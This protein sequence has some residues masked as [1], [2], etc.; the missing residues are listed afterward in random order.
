[1]KLQL[2]RKSFENYVRLGFEYGSGKSIDKKS[3]LDLKKIS[4][5][6][7]AVL[8]VDDI[9]DNSKTRNGKSC[10]YLQK[11]LQ[12]AIVQAELSKV[13]AIQSLTKVMQINKT[14]DSFQK[15]VLEK[16]FDF[17]KNIYLGEQL[18]LELCKSKSDITTIL[19][20]YNLM[21]KLS[22]GGHIKFGLE[23]GQL[24]ANKKPEENLSKIAEHSGIIRQVMDDFNDYF[25]EHHEPFGDF[26]NEENRF[27]EIIFKKQKGNRNQIIKLIKDKKIKQAREIILNEKVRKEIFKKCKLEFNKIQ[28]IQTKFNKE[29]LIEDFN[30]ILTKK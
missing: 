16:I 14:K 28:K 26:I 18:D 11:G 29:I 27:P 25:N 6:D 4:L 1:M 23:I 15:L 30:T 20:K 3:L 21:I 22:T 5:I 24:I 8:I 13:E 9:L 17:F 10:L 2:T 12:G 19:K 7:D